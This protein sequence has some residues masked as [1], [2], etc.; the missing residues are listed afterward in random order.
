MT[1]V[2][3]F[4]EEIFDEFPPKKKLSDMLNVLT[5]LTFIWSGITFF[6]SFFS[7]TMICKQADQMDRTMSNFEEKRGFL[8]SIMK[9]STDALHRSCEMRLPIL[10]AT[11]I[12][13]I[14]CIIGAI[15]MRKLKK[16][17]Y[18]IYLIGEIAF[19]IV[20]VVLIGG[21]FLSLIGV[22]LMPVLF[23]ILYGTQLKNMK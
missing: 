1:D 3:Q 4:H 15:L 7:Y 21:S 14:L 12:C 9:N 6:S 10:I 17:G 22:F 13:L 23:L 8:A 16:N 2:N 18:F 11:I 5:I 20:Y 19:P